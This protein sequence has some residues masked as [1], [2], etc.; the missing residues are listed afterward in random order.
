M[1]QIEIRNL[2]QTGNEEILNSFN[3]A[4]SDYSVPLQL[5]L[6]QLE[7]KLYSE[8]VDT[9]ISVGAF[10]ENKLVGFV[11]HG[12]RKIKGVPVAY[13]AGTGVIPKER[14]ERLTQRMYQFIRPILKREGFKTVFLEVI[15]TNTPAII[16]YKKIGFKEIRPL[17]CYKGEPHIPKINEGITIKE[18]HEISFDSLQKLGELQ[19]TWQ[20]SRETILKMGDSVR[21]FLAFKDNYILGYCILNSKNNRILQMAV[22]NE[23][24]NRLIGTSLLNHIKHKVSEPIS[25]I[26]IDARSTPT[27]HFFEKRNMNKTL[28]QIE[29]KLEIVYD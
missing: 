24:R 22:R 2:S 1:E 12:N 14:G 25:I 16:S 9:S 4:F 3:T 18:I 28:G 29:M 20:N 13:N 19:P 7:F 15:S 8:S 23:F 21:N 11:L 26:N 27:L 10:K 5:D 6:E 17:S